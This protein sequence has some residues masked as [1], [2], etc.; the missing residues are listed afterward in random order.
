MSMQASAHMSSNMPTNIHVN[1]HARIRMRV[2]ISVHECLHTCLY[3]C[4][5]A[6]SSL[7]ATRPPPMPDL[8]P[9]LRLAPY[10]LTPAPPPLRLPIVFTRASSG[11]DTVAV[12][13]RARY[14]YIIA[15]Y[16]YLWHMLVYMC[17]HIST[18]K[19]FVQ[20]SVMLGYAHTCTLFHVSVC[21]NLHSV[22]L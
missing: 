16:P 19:A 14:P 21:A 15:E 9:S 10:P 6:C 18:N 20:V 22:C 1:T 8:P 4:L 17:M 3:R 12:G 7:Q 11:L 2:H 5:C 13:T